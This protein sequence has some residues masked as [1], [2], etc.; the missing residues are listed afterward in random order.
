[1]V[2]NSLG[3]RTSLGLIDPCN[4]RLWVG[5]IYLI[6]REWAAANRVK[7]TIP[8]PYSTQGYDTHVLGLTRFRLSLRVMR[9][10]VRM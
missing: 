9:D 5:L 1:M 10:Q 4:L 6:A 8:A 7:N 2:I 3:S